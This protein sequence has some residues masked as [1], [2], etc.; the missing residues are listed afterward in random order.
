MKSLLT[1]AVVALAFVHF[2]NPSDGSRLY[3][4]NEDASK[5]NATPHEDGFARDAAGAKL[6]VGVRV[7]GPGSTE[8]RKAEDAIASVRI[9]EGKKG[10]SG[11]TLR[12]DATTKLA[13][14]TS[15]FV[16]FGYALKDGGEELRVT[17][18]SDFETRIKVAS[19]FYNDL[20]FVGLRDQVEAD[21]HDH[22]NFT[23]TASAA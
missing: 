23:P 3:V 12:D 16:N 17:P 18:A 8:Y 19:A 11:A 9:K 22:A 13:R 1:A 21:Q 5:F 2:K 7:Y 15:E 20:R 6:P 14:C 4:L 10:L